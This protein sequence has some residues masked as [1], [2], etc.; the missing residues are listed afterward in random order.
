MAINWFPGHMA[1]A[2]K[3]IR[4]AMPDVDFILEILDARIPFSSENPMVVALRGHKPCIKVL[5][6]CD[7]A[8]ARV[9][10][11]WLAHLERIPGVK[12]RA[13]QSNQPSQARALLELGRSLLPRDRT[14][15]RKI[16]VMVLGVPNVGKSTVIN[17]LAR[18]SIAKTG[19]KPAVTKAQQRIH[20]VGDFILL[21]TPGFL[22]PRLSPAAC[23]YRL[24]VTGAVAD[25][26]VDYQDI[27]EFAARF[28]L[29]SYPDALRARYNLDTLPDE[30]KALLEAIAARRAC[31][32]RGGV[33]DFQ[34]VSELL[35][36]ELRQG[37][38]G[39]LSME[40]PPE[41]AVVEAGLAEA[42]LAEAE[43][44]LGEAVGGE[45]GED[46]EG[47]APVEDPV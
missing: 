30:P 27:G 41:V 18:R 14:A 47:D 38:L 40:S 24:A 36:R 19:N 26:V 22:W 17:S 43:L 35:V 7:L 11:A 8:D 12:A 23:G 32:A 31:V 20:N 34:K 16:L 33:V 13:I 4:R 25:T 42:G 39:R 10:E 9:T 1:T 5:N 2:K 37:L 21:D 3:E 45:E 15:H 6:K 44:G 46:V 28:L 29:Q